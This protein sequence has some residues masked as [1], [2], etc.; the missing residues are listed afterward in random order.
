MSNNSLNLNLIQNFHISV[1]KKTALPLRTLNGIRVVL[2]TSCQVYLLFYL[3]HLS[4]KMIFFLKSG[5]YTHGY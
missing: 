2:I 4:R 1:I 5:S 3:I